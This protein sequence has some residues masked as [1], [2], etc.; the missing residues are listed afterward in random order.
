MPA[1]SDRILRA[2]IGR[3][4]GGM[5][6]AEYTGELNPTDPDSRAM[7]DVHLGTEEAEVKFW[8]EEMAKG[9]GYVRID[10]EA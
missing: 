3:T 8:V 9:V 2:R 1:A 6:K 5:Y 10:W 4:S 7:L